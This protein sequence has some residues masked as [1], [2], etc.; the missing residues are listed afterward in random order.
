MEFELNEA[1]LMLERTPAVFKTLLSG[2]PETWTS[3]NESGDSWSPYDVVG[4]LIHGEKT[5]WLVRTKVILQSENKDFE[6]FDR[7][8]QFENSQGRSLTQLLG[9]FQELRKQNLVELK[10]LKLGR[11][12]MNQEG[13]HPEFGAVRLQ[14]LLSAWVVH[15]LG[16]IVQVSRVLAKQYTQ[17]V[18][19]WTK[20]LTVLGQ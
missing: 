12:D 8:A 20:Y 6:P 2:L 7:F 9:E 3:S 14:Q 1:I 4:H 17:A 15:D 13:I 18:G 11:G 5:D 10:A 16:H 19:P